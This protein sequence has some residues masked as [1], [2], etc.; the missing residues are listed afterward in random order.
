MRKILLLL[1]SLCFLY[2]HAYTISNRTEKVLQTICEGNSQEAIEL[3]KRAAATN[4]VVAQYYMGRCYEFGVGLEKN[5]QMAFSMYRRAAERGFPPAM[6]ELA[7]CYRKGI[8]VDRNTA[9]ADEWQKRFLSKNTG[10]KIPDIIEV[11]A[12]HESNSEPTAPLVAEATIKEEKKNGK[13][14]Q[15]P[16]ATN[17]NRP[18]NNKPVDITYKQE[19]EKK[20]DVDIDIPVINATNDKVFA[21][22]IANE[23]YQYVAP[24]KNAINDGEVFAQY[25]E[26]TL[27]L[28]P[29][30]IKLIKDATF[31]N[32][33]IE[34]QTLKMLSIAED[35]E[36]SFIIYYSGHG[37]PD[38]KTQN[39]F[40]MPVDGS[41]SNLTTCFSISDFYDE[42][43]D[44]QCKKTVIIFDA[45]F[46]GA[47]R[48]D[49]M[50]YAARG[51]AIKP[52]SC[53]PKGNTVVIS[54]S[55]GDE[56]SYSFDEQKH[57]LFTYFFLKKL[58]DSSG[59]VTLGDLIASVKKEV[60]RKSLLINRRPQTPTITPSVEIND[61]WE[62]WNLN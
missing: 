58:K 33:K 29:T 54:S 45:C 4:D 22:I 12:S 38:E 50:L 16:T 20:S 47:S 53:V 39:A 48:G 57:G 3:L 40:L 37:L 25:C 52:K 28:P 46:S 55:Q 49:E 30:N 5:D 1:T 44:L 32:L 34:L 36:V 35:G 11:F 41:G 26:Q 23:N 6:M 60:N 17:I 62:N 61:S 43:G 42:I 51:V 13:E 19:E 2:A 7:T 8:G 9:R 56:F 21:L 24:V 59:N 18:S 27:G 31:N 14:N 15:T 10:D